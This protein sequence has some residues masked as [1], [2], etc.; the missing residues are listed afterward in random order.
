MRT[1]VIVTGISGGIGAALR[2]A[3]EHA[4]DRVIG[5]DRKRPAAR[6]RDFVNADLEALCVDARARARTLAQLREQLAGARLRALVNNAAT[7]IVKPFPALT[8]DDWGR[9]LNV[10]L[11]AGALLTQAFTKDLER[12]RGSVVNIA[13]IHARLTK[14]GFAA[15]ATSKAA[16]V[17]LTRSLAVELG[18]RVRVN[19]ICPAAIDTPMLRQG[20]ARRPAGLRRLA[21][22]HP[23]GRIGTSAEVAELA[24]FLASERAGFV[25]GQAWGLDGGIGAMLHDPA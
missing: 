21:R 25:T 1:A 23:A 10:N 7:Q 9:T 8:A 18:G 11:V 4:G 17:G 15:Y 6:L 3:F 19:A 24:V 22:F 16:L 5:L 2:A 13:S 14:P 20:F 12:A